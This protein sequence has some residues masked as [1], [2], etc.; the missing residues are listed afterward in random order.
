MSIVFYGTGQSGTDMFINGSFWGRD[1]WTSASNQFRL[2]FLTSDLRIGSQYDGA[3]SFYGSVDE[4]WLAN[5]SL[6]ASSISSLYSTNAIPE[7]ATVALIAGTIALIGTCIM[8]RIQLVQQ[9]ATA[10]ADSRHDA[11]YRMNIEMKRADPK[12]NEARGAP[13]AV[14]AHL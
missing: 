5:S 11:C 12:R 3:D 14:A 4:V 1:D 10:N 6:G 2:S 9:A 7:P 8:K 13:A